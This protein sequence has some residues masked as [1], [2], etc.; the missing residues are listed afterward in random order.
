MPKQFERKAFFKER[1]KKLNLKPDG[2]K[3]IDKNGK[4]TDLGEKQYKRR[5]FRKGVRD[6]VFTKAKKKG[7]GSVRD[8]NTKV[9]LKRKGRWDMGHKPGFEYKKHK[10]SAAVQGKS[11]KKFLDEHNDPEHYEPEDPSSNS[12]HS[13][14][15]ATNNYLGD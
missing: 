10:I 2:N 3:Y 12:G 13:H 1:C 14:E 6:K 9:R 5:G 7:N 4:L 15:D 11:R 8:P